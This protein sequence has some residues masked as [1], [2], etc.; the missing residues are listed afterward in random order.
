MTRPLTPVQR[1]E[2]AVERY[3]APHSG[4]CSAPTASWRARDSPMTRS[5]TS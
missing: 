5:R 3:A 2:R 1:A 4:P